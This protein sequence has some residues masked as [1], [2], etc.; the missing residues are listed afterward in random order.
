MFLN[1]DKILNTNTF[2]TENFFISFIFVRKILNVGKR[3]SI[4]YIRFDGSQK[5]Q[6]NSMY[7]CEMV[8][9]FL[10]ALNDCCKINY[11]DLHSLYTSFLQVKICLLHHLIS[12]NSKKNVYMYNKTKRQREMDSKA[13]DFI[14]LL[15]MHVWFI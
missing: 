9:L 12:Q 2:I 15:S 4:T 13:A 10:Y 8:N 7:I 3:I 11:L 5:L 6:A 1:P 14:H